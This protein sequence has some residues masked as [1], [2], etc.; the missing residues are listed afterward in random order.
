MANRIVKR[1]E[2]EEERAEQKFGQVKVVRYCCYKDLK[3]IF[4]M[5]LIDSFHVSVTLEQS[6]CIDSQNGKFALLT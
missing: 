2:Y 3:S 4:L 6:S 1:R 5:F